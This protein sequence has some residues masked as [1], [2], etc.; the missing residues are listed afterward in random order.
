MNYTQ[1]HLETSNEPICYVEGEIDDPEIPLTSS[2]RLAMLRAADAAEYEDPKLPA[3]PLDAL[4]APMRNWSEAIAES[5]QVPPC[6]PAL[7]SLTTLAAA[8]Q[9]K[10]TIRAKDDFIENV[11]LYSI[12]IMS[13]GSRKSAVLNAARKPL[14]KYEISK[15]DEMRDK[16]LEDKAAA[17]A[18][19]KLY[20]KAIKNGDGCAAGEF[21]KQLDAIKIQKPLQIVVGSDCTPEKLPVIMTEQNE[22]V[23][24]MDPEGNLFSHMTGLYT[25]SNDE[26]YLK[27]W[28][29]ESVRI[30]RKNSDDVY[31]DSPVLTVALAL[32]PHIIEKIKTEPALRGKGMLGRFIYCFPENTVGNRKTTFQTKSI[33]EKTVED[34]ENLIIEILD[35]QGSVITLDDDAK[36]VFDDFDR[37]IEKRLK[38]DLESICDWASKLPGSVVMRIAGLLAIANKRK[39]IS[40]S[41]MRNAIRIATALIPHALE[42]LGTDI[43]LSESEKLKEY[44]Q[45]R[46]LTRVNRNDLRNAPGYKRS[47]PAQRNLVLQNLVNEGFLIQQKGFFTVNRTSEILRKLHKR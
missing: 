44:I 1:M 16:Y 10:N 27:A 15:A 20:D 23:A 21:A 46:K 18:I 30:H 41:D 38:G 32:Q 37:Q 35:S 39:V 25:K 36:S 9:G 13:P 8:A 14:I 33:D 43:E 12:T 7:I 40:G 31:L 4:P 22:R 45:E 42:A 29:G 2:D 5:M 11:N 34:Y 19:R 26:I 17:E 3:I 28:D 6:M 24:I 47:S